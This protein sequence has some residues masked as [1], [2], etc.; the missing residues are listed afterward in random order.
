MIKKQ[1]EQAMTSFKDALGNTISWT[2][3]QCRMCN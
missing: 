3:G 2:K 1:I